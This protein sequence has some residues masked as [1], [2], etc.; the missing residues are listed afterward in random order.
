MLSGNLDAFALPDV[1]T[2]LAGRGIT[3]RVEIK[4]E[5]V[6]GELSL[7]Q[8]RFV[9]ARL[10]DDESPTTV[11]EALDVAVLLFDGTSGEFQFVTEEW[12]GGPLDLNAEELLA[13]VQNRR[14][15]WADV[16]SSL[17]SLDDP[18]ML[19]NDL[20]DG[21]KEI[22]ITGEHW[23]LLTLVD[24]SRSVQDIARDSASSV[25]QTALALADLARK[26]MLSRG[27]GAKWHGEKDA[28][29]EQAAEEN[30]MDVLR[31]LGGEEGETPQ[32]EA[33]AAA[34][35]TVRPLRGRREDRRR[36]R[37]ST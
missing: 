25:Y 11:D 24:G 12:V 4:R 19:T 13:A 35:A 10:A 30:P 20:P 29:E 18:L 6:A 32:E 3:G 21:T 23:G 7:D 5:E 8:G 36:F 28:P 15:E 17:G 2:F 1:V 34:G 37:R 16:M 31:E 26:G 27:T 33:G 14:Q 9:A 22:T